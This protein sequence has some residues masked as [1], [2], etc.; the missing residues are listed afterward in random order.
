VRREEVEMTGAAATI[1]EAL[2]AAM[3]AETDGHHFYLMAASTTKDPQGKEVFAQLADEEL[4]HL[5]FL[6]EQRESYLATGHAAEA[7]ALGRGRDLSGESPIFSA[8]IKG[9]LQEAHFE[10]SA[11]SIGVSLE[12]SSQSFYREQARAVGD[13]AARRFFEELAE[14]EAEH[15]EALNRQLEELKEDYWAG[16]GFAPF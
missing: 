1:A 16:G 14:W 6:K 11:L 15:A 7:V 2:A 4:S 12:L 9:R 8:A 13:P 3:Q 10:M 5:K